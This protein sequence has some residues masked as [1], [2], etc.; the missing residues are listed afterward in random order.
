MANAPSSKPPKPLNVDYVNPFIEA[1]CYVLR[2]MLNMEVERGAIYRKKG[3]QP[4]HEVSGLINFTGAASGTIVLGMCPEVAFEATGILTGDRPRQ[5]D[6]Q[7]V[8]AVGELTNII[9]GNAKAKLEQLQLSI[10]LPCVIKGRQHAI[11]FP[12]GGVPIG[13]PFVSSAGPLCIE[14]CLVEA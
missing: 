9:S 13:I 14:V 7:V 5:I 6:A 1:T 11:P 2:S 8:D 10:S 4:S 12:H 3:F